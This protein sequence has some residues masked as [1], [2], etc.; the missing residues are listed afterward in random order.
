MSNT[1][2]DLKE[3]TNLEAKDF[4]KEHLRKFA[5]EIIGEARTNLIDAMDSPTTIKAAAEAL[6]RSYFTIRP[7]VEELWKRGILVKSEYQS[8]KGHV[9]VTNY[10]NVLLHF[11]GSQTG[12]MVLSGLNVTLPKESNFDTDMAALYSDFPIPKVILPLKLGTEN[13]DLYK[14]IVASR[15]VQSRYVK[16]FY[17]ASHLMYHVWYRNYLFTMQGVPKERLLEPNPI[18]ARSALKA[19]A[20]QIKQYGDMLDQIVDN[21]LIWNETLTYES[22]RIMGDLP[23]EWAKEA[24]AVVVQGWADGVLN[25]NGRPGT[26]HQ[27]Y[28][29]Q[30]AVLTREIKEQWA[31]HQRLIEEHRNLVTTEEG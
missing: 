22:W 31:I 6:N 21:E 1:E 4:Y 19:I 14:M 17:N 15:E 5:P 13:T 16:L 26:L 7:V 25:V 23:L 24:S 27:D 28:E 9:Y 2:V 10:S 11:S 12:Q 18:Q 29:R 8:K 30:R 3:L 20:K